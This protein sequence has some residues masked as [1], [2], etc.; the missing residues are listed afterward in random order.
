M[1]EDAGLSEDAGYFTDGKDIYLKKGE[2]YVRLSLFDRHFYKLSLYKGV[3]ILE[4]DGL[5]M[6]LVEDFENPRQYSEG[7]VKHL[8]V[9]KGARVLDT[10][11]GLGYTAMAAA[12]KGA[13]VTTC[14]ISNAVIKLAELNPHGEGLFGN[15]NIDIK[16]GNSFDLIK[17][18]ENEFFSFVIHDPPRFS[19]AGELYS[20]EFY[21]ELYRVTKRNA[22][23]FHY[24]GSLGKRKGRSIAMQVKKRLT[25]A[26]FTRIKKDERFQGLF[27]SK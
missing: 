20:T 4:V 15:K 1:L 3:P 11:M 8:E 23:I 13:R 24:V 19:H 22:K 5:R 12:E 26:G 9:K 2:K 18:F 25:A 14:E 7:I 10:C 6:H 16:H 17:E 27:F 21:K